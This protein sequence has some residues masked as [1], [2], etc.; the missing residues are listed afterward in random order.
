MTNPHNDSFDLGGVLMFILL[1]TW[2]VGV[3]TFV[4]H[5]Y[6]VLH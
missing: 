1:I 5:Q 6:G 3:A 4:L 2:A